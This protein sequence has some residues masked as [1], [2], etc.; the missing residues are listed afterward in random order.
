LTADPALAKFRAEIRSCVERALS[1][2]RFPWEKEGRSMSESEGRGLRDD[3]SASR[4]LALHAEHRD[5]RHA[6]PVRDCI[7][8][9]FDGL[10]RPEMN[11]G[12][13]ELPPESMVDPLA[14]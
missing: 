10:A 9:T 5:G 3:P 7:Q 11:G 14:Y 2:A 8:C 1:L 12:D 4:I 6:V 13:G